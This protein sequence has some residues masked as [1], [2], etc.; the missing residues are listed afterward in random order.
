M[1]F[2]RYESRPITRLAH[3]IEEDEVL[4]NAGNSLYEATVDGQEIRFVAYEE[5]E[6]GD[7]IVFLDESDIY[8]VRREVFLARNV[9]E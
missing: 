5:P 2:K 8:H 3:E 4:R 6:A 7:F 9:V 1:S